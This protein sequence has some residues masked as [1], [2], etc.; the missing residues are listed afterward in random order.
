MTAVYLEAVRVEHSALSN[1]PCTE[2]RSL[3]SK[4]IYRGGIICM[5]VKRSTSTVSQNSS[6]RL[7][8]EEKTK[9]FSV[10]GAHAA[11]R[12]LDYRASLLLVHSPI[13]II[14]FHTQNLDSPQIRSAL[15]S[16]LPYYLTNSGISYC[17]LTIGNYF[18]V[19]SRPVVDRLWICFR[20]A[21]ERH[22]LSN[23]SAHQ[24]IRYHDHWLNCQRN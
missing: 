14:V 12:E 20:M 1:C 15:Q 2:M 23:L 8:P 18:T 13:I 5:Q 4:Y 11:M 9:R 3:V 19:L 21:L 7:R 24:L 17:S 22:V 6:V 10:P 16:D